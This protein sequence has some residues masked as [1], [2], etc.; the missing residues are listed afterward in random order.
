MSW[1]RKFRGDATAPIRADYECPVHGRF[2]VTIARVDGDAPDE[3]ACP[4]CGR[5]SCW[6]PPAPHGR[7]KAGEVVQ[8]K[9]M[10][11][12]PQAVCADTRPLADGMPLAEWRRKQ[13][14]VTRDINIKK[15]RARH[16]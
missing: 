5:M 13:E 14:S 12:P 9:T 15:S 6:R 11:Y 16:S 2:D 4:T 1:L 3:T 7:V 10:E 8:G